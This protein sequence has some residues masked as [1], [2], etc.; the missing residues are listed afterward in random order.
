VLGRPGAV[1]VDGDLAGLWRPRKAGPK[2]RI[3]LELWS[4]VPRKRL[5]PEGERLAAFRG[6]R[7]DGFTGD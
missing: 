7:F 2:L 5:E 6:G 1:L 4:P 3:Q